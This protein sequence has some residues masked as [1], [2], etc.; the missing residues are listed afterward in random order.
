MYTVIQ[1]M[2]CD[3]GTET[4]RRVEYLDLREL[5]RG[6]AGPQ[7]PTGPPGPQGSQ[8]PPGPPGQN[9]LTGPPGPPGSIAGGV[10]Y[11]HW[12]RTSCPSTPGTELV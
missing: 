2:Y 9:G 1:I 12:G 5:L 10:S 3:A 7:G 6:P 11:I 4:K 8:G